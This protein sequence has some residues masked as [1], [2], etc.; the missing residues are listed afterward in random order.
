MNEEHSIKDVLGKWK[1]M[2]PPVVEEEPRPWLI[3]IDG[4]LCHIW[5]ESYGDF[6]TFRRGDMDGFRTTEEVQRW[7]ESHPEIRIE[8]A[9]PEVAEG[10]SDDGGQ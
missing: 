7:L 8:Y 5:L 2:F 3:E 6:G 9:D 1:S 10:K 4:K